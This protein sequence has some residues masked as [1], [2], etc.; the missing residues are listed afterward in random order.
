MG[1]GAAPARAFKQRQMSRLQSSSQAEPVVEPL[2]DNFDTHLVLL[3]FFAILLVYWLIRRRGG[4]KR[5]ESE[6]AEDDVP[7]PIAP[8][9]QIIPWGNN[10]DGL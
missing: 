3:G 1:V 2:A 7:A 9:N 6:E 4:S 8:Q 5:A 10:P